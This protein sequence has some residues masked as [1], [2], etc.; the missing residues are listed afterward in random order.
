MKR[1]FVA[2]I[3]T[4]TV[5]ISAGPAASFA[6]SY[7]G[8]AGHGNTGVEPAY[9]GRTGQEIFIQLPNNANSSKASAWS[10]IYLV[11]YPTSTTIGTLDC[12]PDNCDHANVLPSGLGDPSVYP[13][14][15][16]TNQF[17]TFTGGQ[18]IGHDHLLGVDANG[19]IHVTEHVYLVWFT[20]QGASDGAINDEVTTVDQLNADISAGDVAQP[21]DTGLIVH[22]TMVSSATYLTAN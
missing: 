12:T 22:A 4:L 19:Q 14:V 17:G 7:T 11:M 2:A 3:M 13:N 5:I 15:T 6:A 18:V 9:D 16:F 21:L 10:P 20:P 1:L 8:A